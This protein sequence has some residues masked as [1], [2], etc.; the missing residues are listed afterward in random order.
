MDSF[1]ILLQ[2]RAIKAR[3]VLH[4]AT[5][6]L[7]AIFEG[8]DEEGRRALVSAHAT[9]YREFVT[10][11]RAASAALEEA[12]DEFSDAKTRRE[13]LQAAY[14]LAEEVLEIGDQGAEA[15]ERL[16]EAL[17]VIPL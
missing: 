16:C 3:A 8:A 1:L 11:A 2:A 12:A 13:V 7:N 9:A 17:A 6:E 4:L 10:A 5:V 15:L 14:L